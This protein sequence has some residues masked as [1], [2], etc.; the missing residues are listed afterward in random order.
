VVYGVLAALAFVASGVSRFGPPWRAAAIAFGLAVAVASLD[1]ARQARVAS[2]TG[3][4]ADVG[5]DAAGAAATLVGAM[6]IA[7]RRPSPQLE[8]A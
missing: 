3:A 7:S 1:E 4:I 6:W 8:G 5:L 2:R